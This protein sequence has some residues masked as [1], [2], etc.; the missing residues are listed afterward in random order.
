MAKRVLD[1]A[2]P[3]IIILTHDGRLDRTRSIKALPDVI[4]G[5]Q[6]Q[7]YEFV[8]LDEL[9]KHQVEK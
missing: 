1:V 7:G 8:T 2:Q 4:K 9:M 5:Y 6:A 3:G